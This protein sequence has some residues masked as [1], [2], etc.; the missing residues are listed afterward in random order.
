MLVLIIVILIG[1]VVTYS[2]FL[3][4]KSRVSIHGLFLDDKWKPN[5]IY[6]PNVVNDIR[7]TIV[8]TSEQFMKEIMNSKKGFDIIS[9]DRGLDQDM[10]VE[11]YDSRHY[12][13]EFM[14]RYYSDKPQD[15]IPIFYFHGQ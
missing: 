6:P 4:D 11:L 14:C 13:I 8:R 7:W 2:L 15:S 10:S 1:F 5:D 3:S 9:I 12:V